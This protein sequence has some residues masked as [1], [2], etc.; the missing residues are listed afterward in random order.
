LSGAVLLYKY[1]SYTFLPSMIL[2][3][4]LASGINFIFNLLK[5]A[6]ESGVLKVLA[7]YTTFYLT[8][9]TFVEQGPSIELLFLAG[10]ELLEKISL[11]MKNLI[12]G[13]K[14]FDQYI[15]ESSGKLCGF[16]SQS[17]ILWN[18]ATSVWTGVAAFIFVLWVWRISW[19]D[20]RNIE[21][22]QQQVIL[23]L[24]TVAS[25]SLAVYGF[26]LLPEAFKAT[27]S[28]ANTTAQAV[29]N[30]TRNNTIIK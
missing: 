9:T 30:N 28:L 7:V 27:K 17:D 29:K 22:E 12:E 1:S 11:S 5:T 18:S 26:D 24:L 4:R 13:V 25:L 2:F 8:I 10:K 19:Y 20:W 15:A 16:T 21:M 6:L 23:G 14:L 3:S